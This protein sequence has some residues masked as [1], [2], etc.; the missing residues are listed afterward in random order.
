MAFRRPSYSYQTRD[1][2]IRE[3]IQGPNAE[4]FQ[5]ICYPLSVDKET[6]LKYFNDEIALKRIFN[7]YPCNIIKESDTTYKH[8]ISYNTRTDAYYE[9]GNVKEKYLEFWDKGAY[10]YENMSYVPEYMFNR[11]FLTKDRR[12]P[13]LPSFIIYKFDYSPGNFEIIDLQAWSDGYGYQLSDQNLNLKKF[14]KNHSG[15]YLKGEVNGGL[16]WKNTQLFRQDL[17]VQGEVVADSHEC[18]RMD[19]KV[20]LKKIPENNIVDNNKK[21]KD[22]DKEGNVGNAT[23]LDKEY[24][25]KDEDGINENVNENMK[26]KSNDE[27]VEKSRKIDGI[28]NNKFIFNVIKH[29]LKPHMY[30]HRIS[31]N[32]R[33]NAYY[34]NGNFKTKYIR[35]WNRGTLKSENIILYPEYL[36]RD[37]ICLTRC[38]K[39]IVTEKSIAFIIWKFDYRP[40][41]Y[42]ISS[43]LIKLKHAISFLNSSKVICSI[44]P[45]PTVKNP[46]PTWSIIPFETKLNPSSNIRESDTFE[47]LTDQ[48]EGEYG[49]LLKVEM[50]CDYDGNRFM[51]KSTRLFNQKRREIGPLV[52]D[53][54]S[55]VMD[56]K[57]DL[58][59]DII[60]DDELNTVSNNDSVTFN[61]SKTSDFTIKLKTE[62]LVEGEDE[63]TNE[64]DMEN[65][66]K[67]ENENEQFYVH[68]Q[69]LS[70][71]SYYFKALL[72]S[73]MIE[74]QDRYLILP[75]ISYEML[76][77]I[78]LYMYTNE[79]IDTN[80]LEDWI[81][82]IY[83]ASRF[84]IP[85]LIQRCEKAISRYVTQENL[86][87]IKSI[88]ENCGANQLI[89]FCD[90]F[91]IKEE[92]E[93]EE[94]EGGNEENKL[95]D[96]FNNSNKVLQSSLSIIEKAIITIENEKQKRLDFEISGSSP[97]PTTSFSNILKE[98]RGL[99]NNKTI[100]SLPP[101][102]L[103]RQ[104]DKLPENLANHK[105]NRTSRFIKIDGLASTII[106]NDITYLSREVNGLQRS[107]G[108]NVGKYL[109]C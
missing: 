104:W 41:N 39:H 85:H 40:G 66:G 36:G 87:E 12:Y 101:S 68:A 43:L 99:H 91:K 70:N 8:R 5:E 89:R 73:Q 79:I 103:L 15:F 35:G 72:N 42:V 50:S 49:F 26:D 63:Q 48:L 74:S 9:N 54:E 60:C 2:D 109:K 25:R 78:L 1:M 30:K 11:T 47:V 93:G 86:V 96:E 80:D 45:L 71:K 83:F 75:D 61:D 57:V 52:D 88:A 95:L 21:V 56:I 94:G 81:D 62:E 97:S 105:I 82:L 10:K 28:F 44:S 64:E 106:T 4:Q 37:N 65:E 69:I 13:E 24:E 77:K 29:E 98:P 90:W 53:D 17:R 108:K 20:Q 102:S 67:N 58:V 3:N 27:I 76:E 31:Y 6:A 38:S 23:K 33:T 59:N 32:T 55:V 51:W 18:L 84:V 100:K 16:L 14:V 107:I 7:K 22:E 19:V 92:V 34:E 46:N